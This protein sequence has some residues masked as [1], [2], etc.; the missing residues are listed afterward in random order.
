VIPPPPI[1]PP[2]PKVLRVIAQ[3]EGTC[4][5]LEHDPHSDGEFSVGITEHTPEDLADK[6]HRH[7]RHPAA[8]VDMVLTAGQMKQFTPGKRYVVTIGEVEP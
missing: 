6:D 5:R 4:V 3:F 1:S 8:A 7:H 2:K